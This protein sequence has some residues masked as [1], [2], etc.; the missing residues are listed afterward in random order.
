MP[1]LYR[2]F[3]TVDSN[4]IPVFS[5]H[6]DREYPDK[7]KSFFAHESF[8]TILNQLVDML[9]MGS[10]EKN[11][12]LWMYGAYGTGKTFASFVIKHL[13]EDD[14]LAV[15]D[16][17]EVNSILP[18]YARILG[19]RNKGQTLVVHRSSSA[20]VIGQNRLFNCIIESV[21]G[22]LRKGGYS[23]LG[24]K[25]RY[26]TII[27]TLKDPNSAFNFE[28]VFEKH[29][30][31]FDGYSSSASIIKDLED[32]P[33]EDCA[34]L[35]EAI[36]EVAEQEHYSWDTSVTDIIDW[37]DD[38]VKGNKLYSIVFIWDEFTEFF[39]NNQNNIT[40]L[41]EIA[42]A[43]AN[44]KFYLLLI[45]HSNQQIIND[46]SARKII[47]ARFKLCM[48]EMAD[49]TAFKLMGQALKLNPDLSNEWEREVGNLWSKVERSTR[50]S[51]IQR[52]PEIKED[53]LRRLLPLHP[54]AAYLLKVISKDI[55]S[56]QR[57]MF[58]FLNGE[59]SQGEQ[60]KTNFSWFLQEH[61]TELNTWN[62][63]TAD[64]LWTYFFTDDNVDFDMVFKT[65]I[66]QYNNYLP[67]CDGDEDK[68]RILRVALLLSAMQQKSGASR[69]QGQSSLLRPTLNNIA[70]AFSGTPIESKVEFVMSWFVQKGIF[71]KVV[72]NNDVLYV[73]PA[74]DI[75]KE[76]FEALREEIRK[77][78]TFERLLNDTEN[79]I[80]DQFKPNDFLKYRFEVYAI[81]PSDYRNALERGI[82]LKKNM[83]PMFFMFSKN[84]A[85]QSRAQSIISKILEADRR[86]VVVDFSGQIFTDAAFDRFIESKTE[87]RYYS[88]NPNYRNQLNLAKANVGRIIEEWKSKLI[89]TNLSVYTQVSGTGVQIQGIGNLRRLFKEINSQYFGCGLEEIS[90]NDKLFSPG[91]FSETIVQIAMDRANI[92]TNM[93]YVREIINNLSNKGIWN[94]PDYLHAHPDHPVS[95][96]KV[97]INEVVEAAFEQKRMVAITDIWQSLEEPPFG[98][99]N[100]QGAAFLLGFLLKE[101][102]DGSYYKY[103][104]ANTV[105]LNHTDLSSLI[106]GA[107]RE[108]PKAK[109]QYIVKQTPEHIEFCRIT[110]GIFKISRDK[111][112]SIDDIAKNISL[113][114]SNNGYP[115]WSLISFIDYELNNEKLKDQLKEAISLYCRLVSVNQTTSGDRTT[116]AEALYKL[117]INTPG[118]KGLLA[119]LIKVE[120]LKTGLEL[121]IGGYKPD[122]IQVT[123]RLG[124]PPQDMLIMLKAKLSADSSYLWVE[125]D[126]NR[127]IDNLYIDYRLIDS[128]NNIL[129][130]KKSK[131]EDAQHSLIKRIGLIK[132]PEVLL[133]Q[134][135]PQL[136]PILQC[137]KSVVNNNIQD[138]N[139]VSNTINDHALAFNNFFENQFAVFSSILIK[140]LDTPLS[141]DELEE[142]FDKV[143]DGTYSHGAEKFV[144]RIKKLLDEYRKNKKI[145]QLYQAWLERTGTQSP[146]SWSEK[147]LIP[148]ICLFQTNSDIATKAFD[149]INNHTRVTVNEEEICQAIAFI[150]SDEL[151]ILNNINVCNESF[152][153]V[154]CGEYAYIID[155]IEDL[156]KVIA[157]EVGMNPYAWMASSKRSV[158]ECI[159]RYAA[160]LYETR[161]RQKVKE[162]IRSLSPE[163]AQQYLD[164]LI[165]D[166][167]LVGISILKE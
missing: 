99:L 23:Y 16:Y 114:L 112:N 45:T 4:F 3:I 106:L 80:F 143:E 119:E 96:M 74:G 126:T 83:I 154:F 151:N 135:C 81:T 12:P 138:K 52:A 100:C 158:D 60:P 125:G 163:R 5:A 43:S 35:L 139:A 10:N 144:L 14:L 88:N 110:G 147:F 104:G 131:Y 105:G 123:R 72:E 103:D 84:E 39:K 64:Y 117:Y 157:Q 6:S 90:I 29:K 79:A 41:Q 77:Q 51:I 66:S 115:L 91:G 116:I 2:D 92:P 44:I 48:I 46:S 146:I 141:T 36:I 161:Y 9:E 47:E 98:L 76:R 31:K 86:M 21:K 152:I 150:N 24:H 8:K 26:E 155:D 101:F 42:Q 67:L 54:Y 165:E 111:Q 27:A 127:Q 159:K 109:S 73:P 164:E 69:V 49:T 129:T 61:S 132:I 15:R 56:N 85:D 134:E 17:C 13:L 166:N 156:K 62:F 153:S 133:E 137:I 121:H 78:I 145:T 34:E 32:L 162:K 120:N 148:I 122:L 58:Q 7:W 97:K 75:D 149:L 93:G 95:R 18:L 50:N 160:R 53:E 40:G 70:T 82:S 30:L 87:E 63:L 65:A 11:R 136:K 28:R 167:P 89:I 108:L 1:R 19:I 118:L 124:V 68:E 22:A 55:S 130:E 128:I 59:S 37:L 38:V 142:L 107:V 25:S 33:I 57:T 102:A 94:N 113:F 20:S 140:E 71:G